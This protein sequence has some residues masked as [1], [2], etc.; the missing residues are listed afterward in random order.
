MGQQITT[1]WINQTWPV[2]FDNVGHDAYWIL[3]GINLLGLIVVVLFWSETKGVSLEHMDKVFGE[4][5][6]VDMWRADN[7]INMPG[8][9]S[10]EE[11]RQVT[12]VA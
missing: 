3:A 7:K 4:A 2:M 9:E 10:A 11:K 8:K 1:L 5:N 6:K 12:E